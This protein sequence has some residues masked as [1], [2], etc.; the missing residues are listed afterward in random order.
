MLENQ[1]K[2]LTARRRR[3]RREGPSLLEQEQMYWDAGLM[4]DTTGRPWRMKDV[5]NY[6]REDMAQY[7]ALPRN[8]R[9]AIKY[10]KGWS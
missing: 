8:V 9:D 6:H 1:M 3:Y 10:G 5:E 2:R 7:D 4:R